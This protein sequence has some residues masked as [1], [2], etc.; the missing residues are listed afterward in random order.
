MAETVRDLMTSNPHIVG[1]DDSIADA[2]RAMRDGDI[3]AVIVHDGD[4]VRGI[5]TDRDIVIR[6][7][8]DGRAPDEVTAGEIASA[9]LAAIAPDA[10]PLEAVRLM[11]ARAVRRLLVVDGETAVGIIT[12]GDLAVARDPDSAL[13]QVSAAPANR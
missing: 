11:E 4:R 7:V 2:A 12:M 6:A 13:A 8:A 5:L 10:D 3:G 1:A 9:E